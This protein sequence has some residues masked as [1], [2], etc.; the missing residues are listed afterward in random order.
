MVILAIIYLIMENEV[1]YDY[2]SLFRRHSRFR[3]VASSGI[4]DITKTIH[5]NNRDASI[6]HRE[7]HT[8]ETDG[9]LRNVK[10]REL[11]KNHRLP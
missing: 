3:R 4:K 6:P 2:N 8:I 9:P 10:V 5:R 11:N 7:I 1:F